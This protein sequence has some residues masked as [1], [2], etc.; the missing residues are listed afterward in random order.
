MRKAKLGKTYEELYGIE[1]AREIRLKRSQAMK[2]QN[3]PMYGKSQLAESIRKRTEARRRNNSYKNTEEQKRKISETLKRKYKSGERVSAQLGTKL[4]KKQKRE[5][6]IR[7]KQIY[8]N[9]K[10]REK[11]SKQRKDEYNKG[12]RKPYWLNKKMSEEHKQKISNAHK[13]LIL[14]NPTY[15]R[16]LINRG[17]N[18]K[19]NKGERVLIDLFKQLNLPY[20]YVGD[21]SVR[22]GT[23]NPD[24]IDSTGFGADPEGN[25]EWNIYE[26]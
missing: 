10:I 18:E 19:P 3:H 11:M 5:H 4:T 20:I 15:L 7:L 13:N 12:I 16:E 2:G 25:G 6:S 9:P 1:K 26:V 17:S 24:F 14:N 8:A 23:L 22:V 21:G